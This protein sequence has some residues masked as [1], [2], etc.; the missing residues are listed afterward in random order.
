MEKNLSDSIVLHS[1]KIQLMQHVFCVE[2]PLFLN[3]V[4][5]V[6]KGCL[7]GEHTGIW[8]QL[9]P[10]QLEQVHP[11][12]STW[13]QRDDETIVCKPKSHHDFFEPVWWRS[14]D[15]RFTFLY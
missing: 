7:S 3:H 1:K 11:W 9:Q 8:L 5:Y 15:A 4:A 12:G 14:V 2:H 13:L 10:L 6:V